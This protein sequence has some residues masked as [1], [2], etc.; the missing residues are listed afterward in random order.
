MD[1][2]NG[3]SSFS[4]PFSSF[5]VCMVMVMVMGVVVVTI[6]EVLVTTMLSPL[7]TG[8]FDHMIHVLVTI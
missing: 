3:G 7:Y 2:K 5:V 4:S 1:L 6:L 8:Y